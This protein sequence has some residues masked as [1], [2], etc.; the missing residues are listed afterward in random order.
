MKLLFS[1]VF[2]I[3]LSTAFCDEGAQISNQEDIFSSSND[4]ATDYVH[5]DGA[6]VNQVNDDGF[7][8]V[9]YPNRSE[10]KACVR[11]CNRKRTRGKQLTRCE[12]MH[13]LRK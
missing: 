9:N 11:E 3:F 7:Y 5:D 13:L 8:L 12:C 10:Y 1:F 2:C 4:A 6:E